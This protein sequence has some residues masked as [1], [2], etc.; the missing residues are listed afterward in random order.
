MFERNRKIQKAQV[1]NNNLVENN[2]VEQKIQKA[3]VDNNNL[4]KNNLVEQNNSGSNTTL[5]STH[6]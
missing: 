3:Q 5:K 4:V 6:S 2:L 1:D